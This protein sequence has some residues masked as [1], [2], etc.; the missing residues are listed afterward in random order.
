MTITVSSGVRS[1]DMPVCKTSNKLIKSHSQF[2]NA[3]N[4]SPLTFNVSDALADE[5]STNVSWL[6]GVTL[7]RHE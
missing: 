7:A 5:A 6:L 2:K 1:K 4:Y 3:L